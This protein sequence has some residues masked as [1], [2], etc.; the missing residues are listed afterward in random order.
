MV[1]ASNCIIDTSN[2]RINIQVLSTASGSYT[3]DT[4]NGAVDLKV[5][6]AASYRLN[7]E[8]SNADV[9]FTLPNL[10]YT[11]DTRTSKVAQT[12][13]YDTADNKITVNIQTSNSDVTV[14]KNVAGI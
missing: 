1:D 2:A 13:G 11:R 4:S 14:N 3:L 10:T 12:V 5:G 9:T 7:A 6:A 8:T